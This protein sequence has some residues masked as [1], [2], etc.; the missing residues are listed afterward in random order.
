MIPSPSNNPFRN[1]RGCKFLRFPSLRF[2]PATCNTTFN[3][4][5]SKTTKER[6]RNKRYRATIR[7]SESLSNN[8]I[9][10]VY[11]DLSFSRGIK[12][13]VSSNYLRATP[14]FVHL[15]DRWSTPSVLFFRDASLPLLNQSIPLPRGFYVDVNAKSE[16]LI[17]QAKFTSIVG[18]KGEK[19]RG[20][21]AS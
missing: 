10:H 1:S 20:K 7:S 21:F 15:R 4:N 12:L 3:Y 11:T 18:E 16:I 6:E 2:R 19:E 8:P 14:F 5:P 9:T 17:S 13:Q